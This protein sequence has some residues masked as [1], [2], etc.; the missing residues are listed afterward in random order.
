MKEVDQLVAMLTHGLFISDHW[1]QRPCL[2]R[3]GELFL[4]PANLPRLPELAMQH[5][6]ELPHAVRFYHKRKP[7]SLRKVYPAREYRN[8]EDVAL[9]LAMRTTIVLYEFYRVNSFYQEVAESFEQKLGARYQVAAYLSLTGTAGAKK[10]RDKQHVFAFQHFGLSKWR[11]YDRS[12]RTLIREVIL[13]PGNILYIPRTFF[14]RVQRLT[15]TTCHVSLGLSW[16]RIY[17]DYRTPRAEM[18]AL[19]TNPILQQALAPEERG[20]TG[21]A[22][23]RTI[24]YCLGLK[25][26]RLP[27]NRT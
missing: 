14:H 5:G 7:F 23:K 13:R 8:A 3:A 21:T 4:G 17:K 22:L 11:I 10:H 24:D 1:M 6:R 18:T 19:F 25:G 27:S 9:Y 15:R 2:F 26:A 12:G 20:L 16:G